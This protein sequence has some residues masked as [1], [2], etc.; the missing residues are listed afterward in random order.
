MRTYLIHYDEIS[1]K[2][3]NRGMFET[4]LQR[5]I[6]RALRGLGVLDIRQLY[7][8]MR[9]DQSDEGDAAELETRLGRVYGIAHIDPVTVAPLELSAIESVV[10]V[11]VG[12]ER[13]KSFAV[14]SRRVNKEFPL[15][16]MQLNAHLGER[17][18]RLSGAR[19]DLDAPECV[20]NVLLLNRDAFL[21]H[22]KIAGP[23]GMP[24]GVAGKVALLLSGGIDSPV[25]GERLLK[26][27]CEL[28]FIH[29]HSAPFTSRASQEKAVDLAHALCRDRVESSLYL[30]ALGDVQRRIATDAPEELRVV[31][32]RR[33]MVRIAERIAL[34]CGCMA[35]AT[36]DVIGQVASQTLPNLHVVDRAVP[37]SILRPLLS[38]DKYEIRA[39]AERIGTYE[40]SV[41][42]DADCCTYLMPRNPRT[43]AKLWEVEKVEATLDLEPLLEAAT[44]GAEAR[45]IGIDGVRSRPLDAPLASVPG[46]CGSV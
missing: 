28:R 38:F 18:A 22:R 30:V 7:G 8:R 29:F 3:R 45:R 32:Y 41:L 20:F 11:A 40:I 17:I 16:S 26:R 35:L 33:A 1:L 10:D 31:L 9:L 23:G 27:G 34:Q 39:L 24:I 36:G 19:V 12:V 4:Q 46:S 6:K 42:P 21:Y 25:A 15:S 14:R 5:N 43:H 2:G 44:L 13:F 37:M